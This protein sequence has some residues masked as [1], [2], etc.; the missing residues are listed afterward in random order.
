MDWTE[1]TWIQEISFCFEWLGKNMFWKKQKKHFLK[2]LN[3]EIMIQILEFSFVGMNN[4]NLRSNSVLQGSGGQS[5]P[6][7]CHPRWDSSF[8]PDM[9]SSS[10][11]FRPFQDLHHNYSINFDIHLICSILEKKIDKKVVFLYANCSKTKKHKIKKDQFIFF[12]KN[13]YNCFFLK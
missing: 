11:V 7:N 2:H 13:M 12:I 1:W 4:E 6:L 8:R 3:R 10:P 5:L 9:A